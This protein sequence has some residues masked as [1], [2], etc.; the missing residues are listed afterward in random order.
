[1][2][3]F[4]RKIFIKDYENISDSKVREA[5]GKLASFVG[6]F[7]NLFLF[8]FKLF[9]GIISSSVSIIADSINN[10]S[11]MGSSIITLVGFKL[12]NA[13]ADEDHPYGHQ[14]IE[15]ISGLIV[16]IIIIFVGGNLL[17]TSVEKIFNYEVVHTENNILFIS[18][19]ILS[20]SIL[21]KLWQSL[22]NRKVGKI[23]NSLA[24]EATADDSRN[25]CISTGVILL[26]NIVLLFYKD[27]PFSLDGA[28]GILV[29]LFILY[30]GVN[31]I[32]E[33]MNPLIGATVEN[34]FVKNII[35]Y[36]KKEPAVLGI[37]DP[38]CHMYGPTKCFM[39]LHV[40]VDAKQ[41]MLEIHDV[42]DNIERSVLKE[43][44]VELTIHMDPIQ[45]DN[46]EINELRS[47]VKEAIKSIS[48]RLSIHDFRV[49]V[50]PTHTNIIFDMV[51][52]YK[53]EMKE[54]EIFKKLEE[55]IYDE[56]KKYYFVIDVD[57]E[58][59]KDDN[60]NEEY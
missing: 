57:R 5:H 37:H 13:P 4:L 30:S 15:Y 40:E 26:G 35:D 10:L 42:I 46:E 29:S 22:F 33:T 3:T 43:F 60:L 8:V 11:D 55:L 2:I 32:K 47:R 34:E 45:T 24:L 52:P 1:M 59:V 27:F 18:I 16:A 19:A 23:I 17:I 53:F 21:V 14:R 50:G 48:K 54:E 41:D 9:A 6:V 12:A 44:G 39:T 36:I 31:L 58:F 7:S 56:D 20:I 28:M 25:D 38:V 49:V 51:I